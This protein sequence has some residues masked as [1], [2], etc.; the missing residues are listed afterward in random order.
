M[1]ALRFFMSSFG[2]EDVY[3]TKKQYLKP[4]SF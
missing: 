2:N 4:F 1:S 3:N